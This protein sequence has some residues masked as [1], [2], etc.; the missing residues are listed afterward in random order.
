M[1]VDGGAFLVFGNAGEGQPGVLGEARLCDAG[2]GGEVTSDADD[3]AVPQ[4]GGV[5]VPEDVAG[6]VVAVGA[7]RFADSRVI[8]GMDQAAAEGPPV[9]ACA[10]VSAGAAPFA[11]TVD[12]TEGRGGQG[13]EEPGAVAHGGRDVLA[14]EETRADEVV[15]VAGMEAGAGRADGGASVAAADE[16]A[17]AGFVAGVVVVEDLTGFPVQGGG[18]AGEVDGVGAA[19]GCGDLLQPA[20]ESGVLGDA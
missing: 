4:L 8:L 3:E 14:A 9:F 10:A 20:G 16:E 7:E 19:T 1:D 12:R 13:D 6:V 17:F 5:C 18:G 15:G 11:S 2:R